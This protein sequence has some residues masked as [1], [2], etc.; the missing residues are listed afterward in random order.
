MTVVSFLDQGPVSE[1]TGPSQSHHE[2]VRLAQLAEE[3]GYVRYWVAEHHGV[4]NM[5]IAA[6]EIMIGHIA[7]RTSTIRVGAGGIMLPNHTPLHVAEQFRTLE[8]LH[9]G[10]ID[11]GIG[12]STG[13]G[14]DPTKD[15]LLRYPDAIERFAEHLT[16]LLAVGRGHGTGSPDSYGLRTASPSDAVLPEV[17]V[18]GS[19]VNS[20]RFAGAAGLGYA[21]FCV[22][23]RD[24]RAVDALRSYRAAFVPAIPGARPRGVLALRVWVGDDQEHAEALAASERLAVLDYLAGTPKVLEPMDAALRRKLTAEQWAISQ[25]LDMTSDLVGGVEPVR[26]R[27]ASLLDRTGADEVIAISNIHDPA[28][29]RGCLRRLA[30]AAADL[31]AGSAL[32]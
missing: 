7:N 3:L 5:A 28:E 25:S 13:T 30:E 6:P 31:V 2:S 8:T 21:F 10:R 1:A 18:L 24:E 22:N 17:F 20:A 12:R 11:L 26:Q 23:Q 19:S 32:V 4:A 29:R 14:D 9:P 16:Q 27:L 15:A